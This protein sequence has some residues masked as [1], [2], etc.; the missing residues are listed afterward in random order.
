MRARF[1]E[2]Q[3]A[4]LRARGLRQL[5]VLGAGLDT[6]VYRAPSPELPLHV[7]EVD[8]PATQRWKQDRLAE[9]R[10]P[11]PAHL[12]FVPVNFEQDS[13]GRELE[14]AGLDVRQPTFFSWLGMTPYLTPEAIHETLASVA[15]A[16]A[17]GGGIVFDYA[18]TPESLTFM[19]RIVYHAIADRV[20]AAG[21]PW[22][23]GFTPA[24]L[25]ADART[26]GFAVAQDIGPDTLHSRYLAHRTDGLSIGHLAHLMWAGAR[27]P[28]D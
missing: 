4:H 27:A 28:S 15:A 8:H 2:D 16:T 7:W 5:V 21:E 13:L 12:T 9:G 1:A 20:R 19:Q 11:V 14:H 6:F 10:I 25:E 22:L 3:L 17:A 18:L 23:S 24:A 26:L